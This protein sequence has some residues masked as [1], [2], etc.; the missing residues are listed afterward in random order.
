V[1]E[2]DVAGC[3]DDPEYFRT[4]LWEPVMSVQC[5]TCHNAAGSAAGTRMVLTPAG[6]P[7]AEENNFNAVRAVARL[8]FDG[9][10]LLLLKPSGQHPLGHGGG[11]IL[12]PDSARSADFQRFTERVQGVSGAC[13]ATPPAQP[14]PS[15]HLDPSA[16]PHQRML[17]RLD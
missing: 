5:I 2:P 16:R 10:S 9:T 8:R 17:T 13:E 7:G 12:S 15:D 4:Q 11:T 1:N 14:S 6:A 3:P